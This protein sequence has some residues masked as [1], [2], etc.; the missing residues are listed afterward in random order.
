MDKLPKP[1]RAFEQEHPEIFKAYESLG[2]VIAQKAPF[3]PRLRELMKLAMA[4]G[5]GSEGAVHSH[6]H[7]A[8]EA[9]ATSTEVEQTVLLGV[10][11]L[12]FPK[13]M[14][15]LTWVKAAIGAS[16]G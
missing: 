13:M 16:A 1:Y 11:T 14:A 7:R 10:T 8:L 15:A 3:D 12:G 6:T 2:E 9:G 5:L 4:A